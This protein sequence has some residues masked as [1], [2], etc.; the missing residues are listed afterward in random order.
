VLTSHTKSSCPS[1]N[2]TSE[3]LASPYPECSKW[4]EQVVTRLKNHP[5]D[6]VVLANFV[7]GDLGG[8]GSDAVEAWSKAV[9]QTVSLLSIGSTVLVLADTP[10]FEISP[11]VCLS[12]HLTNPGACARSPKDA[13]SPTIASAVQTA[14]KRGGGT[15]VDLTRY[16]CD[17]ALCPVIIGNTLVYR[18]SQ[19]LTASFSTLM[20][21]V[22]GASIVRSIGESND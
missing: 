13:L 17:D 10:D 20:A 21:D 1:F 14:T 18:D 9:E 6:V 15:F 4:R 16:L 11:P 12:A 22:L 3:S 7:D 5:P 8:R 19:H 2:V